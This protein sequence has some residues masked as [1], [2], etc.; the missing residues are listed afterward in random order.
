MTESEFR[1]EEPGGGARLGTRA[2]MLIAAAAA[3]V[4]AGAAVVYAAVASDGP[5]A[6]R[7][8]DVPGV[9]RADGARLR[10]L[11]N[12]LLS[13]VSLQDPSGPRSVSA[14]QCDRAYAAAG[15]VACLRPVGALGGTHL[16]VLDG[17]L[18]E[19]RSIPLTGFPNRLR[20]SDSGRMIAWTLFVSGDAYAGGE[21]STRAGVLDM[22]TGTVV[23]S[24]EEFAVTVDG[25]PHRA[26]D[27]NVWGITFTG[28]DNR[29]FATVGTAG[30]R[31]LAEGDLAG[32]TLKTVADGVECPSLSPDETRVAFK[33][34]VGGDPARGWRLS[35]LDLATKKVAATV[36][37]RSVD[38]QAI[39]LD[40]HTLAYGLQ[41]SDGVNDVWAVPADGT[42]AARLLVPGANS[43]SLQPS[44]DHA[45]V[46]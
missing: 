34:A 20:V 26:A 36:E 39:W 31:Y 25:R 12:G 14:Q 46:R 18:R 17:D 32:R 6:A 28:D 7:E 42:G 29:F 24:V 40:D 30:H 38:D 37:T 21:F 33:S 3:V 1:E 35:V 15:T 11:D 2:R 43:P 13:E 4:L 27:V 22:R 19:V 9:V 16:A 8:S 41:R 5:T 45:E 44:R 10:V 23:A